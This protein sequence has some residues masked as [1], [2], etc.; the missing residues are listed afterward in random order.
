M[1]KKPFPVLFSCSVSVCTTM[2]LTT[3]PWKDVG[4]RESNAPSSKKGLLHRGLGGP[5]GK[6]GQRGL[7]LLGCHFPRGCRTLLSS[8]LFLLA[9]MCIHTLFLMNLS[10]HLS[11]KTLSSSMAC[12]SYGAKPHTSRIMCRMNLVC[13]VRHLR[14]FAVPWLVR[15]L[16]HFVALVEAHSH[17]VAQSHAAAP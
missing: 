11:L 4:R 8:S 3:V 16:S 10:T 17:R 9:W 12:F 7:V 15:V 13:L 14:R 6:V 1:I 2:T 5:W